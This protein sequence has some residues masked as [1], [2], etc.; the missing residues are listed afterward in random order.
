ME[1]NNNQ[2][3]DYLKLLYDKGLLIKRHREFQEKQYLYCQRISYY[4]QFSRLKIILNLNNGIVYTDYDI[5]TKKI[6]NKMK[7]DIESML[8]KEFPD[9]YYLKEHREKKDLNIQ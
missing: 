1:K 9:L 2:K 5:E 3:I 4:L 8:K 7:K 6:I